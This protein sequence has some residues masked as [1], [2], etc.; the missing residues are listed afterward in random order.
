MSGFHNLD[1][2]EL[3]SGTVFIDKRRVLSALPYL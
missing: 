3:L 1:G 2:T